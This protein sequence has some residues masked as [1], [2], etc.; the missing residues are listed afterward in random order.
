MQKILAMMASVAL[1]GACAATKAETP[2]TAFVHLFEWQ[3]DDVASECENQLGPKGF[4][5]VQVSPPQKSVDGSQ[6]WTR[7]QPVS[8]SIEGRSGSRAQFASMVSRCKAV[9]VDIYVDA[10]INHMAAWDRNFPEVPYGPNDFHNCTSDIDYGNTWSIQNCD[11]VGLNDLKTESDYVQQKIAD[12]LNDLTSLGVAGFRIDAAKHI[13]AADINGIKSRLTGNPY[14]FQEVIG[15]GGEP[16]TTMDYNWIGDV[17]EFNFSNTLGHYFKLRG[18]LR[19]ISNIGSWSGWLPSTDAVVFVANHDNQRQNTGNIITHKDGNNANNMAHVFMLGWPYGYPK[20]M[21]SYDWQDHDQGPPPQGA[22][23]CNNG[24]LCEHRNRAIANM[25][26]FRNHTAAHWGVTDYWDNGNNQMAWGRGGLGFVAIN[27]EG[28]DLSHSFQTGMPEGIYCDILQGDFDTLTGSC[29]GPTVTI[30]GNGNGTFQ[31]YYHNASAIHVGARVGEPCSDCPGSSSSSGGSSSSGSSS[32]GSS[33]GSSSSSSSSS[34]G[35][36][37]T[38]FTCNNGYTYWGQSVYV[39]GNI[40]ELGNWNPASA[41]KLNPDNYPSWNGSINLPTD[42][43]VEWKCLKRE[44]QNP[45]AGIEWQNGSNNSF[46]SGQSL[47][48]SASF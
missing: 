27:M 45:S 12:Y 21:S 38:A 30:D 23:S 42:Q 3:W 34:G 32:G 37:D 4:S 24:W 13:P 26:G 2:R 20:I 5:A 16:V 43:A 47:S 31:V 19:E 36:I 7:Y 11:L 40:S 33:S 44:E 8:Y 28:N 35:R 18:P 46:T 10:V 48:P 17:T 6:W 39:V 22:S 15:A 1:A 9:G 41:Q 14:I 25:V 29:S